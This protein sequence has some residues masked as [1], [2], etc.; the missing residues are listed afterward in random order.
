MRDEPECGFI[1]K[2]SIYISTINWAFVFIDCLYFGII[3]VKDSEI[4]T[5]SHELLFLKLSTRSKL[6]FWNFPTPLRI[7]IG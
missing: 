3:P 4:I 6:I 7:L 5:V 1:D 2:T